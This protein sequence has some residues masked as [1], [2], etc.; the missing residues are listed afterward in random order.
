MLIP[1]EVRGKNYQR[2]GEWFVIESSSLPISIS[3]NTKPISKERLSKLVYK[4]LLPHYD[5]PHRDNGNAHIAT[6]G[7]NLCGTHYISGQLRHPE[8]RMLRLSRANNPV[9]FQAY[10]NTALNSWSASGNVD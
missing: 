9:I 2:Q 5:L 1:K 10:E 3:G 6:R 7:M 8:H 4:S